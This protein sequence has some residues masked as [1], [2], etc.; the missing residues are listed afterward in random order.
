MPTRRGW[1]LLGA[2]VGLYAGARILGLVPLA[3]LAAQGGLLLAGAVTWTLTRRPQVRAGRE[4]SAC[5]QVGVE[6]RVGLDVTNTG[7]RRTPTLAVTDAFDGGRGTSRFLVAPLA[8]GGSSRA[9]YRIPTDRRG[10]YRLGPL[11]LAAGDPF[12]LARTRRRAAGITEVIVHPRVHDVIAPPERGGD[13]LDY[14]ARS[15]RG[16]PEPG[17]EFHTLRDYEHGDDLRRVHWR[18]T[19]RRGSLMIRQEEAR[20]RAPVV[21][22]L[23]VRSGGHDRAS[24]ETAVEAAASIIAALIRDER[25][26]TLFTT[27]GERVG[28]PGRRHLASV[29]DAL[30]VIE[31]GGPDRMTALLG[32][33]RAAALVA[34]MGRMR[35]GDAA[36]LTLLVRG[37][38]LLALVATRDAA[39]ALPGRRGTSMVVSVGHD[40]PFDRAWNECILRWEHGTARRR[41]ASLSQ[42]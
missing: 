11:H 18:S 28:S 1:S 10:L 33:R 36:A 15:V 41:P 20:R 22:L 42:R 31:P 32:G 13:D 8:P 21:V 14:D 3:L 2:I 30:A 16:R 19:A 39:E 24:F 26:V 27:T 4:V 6:G 17:G 12:G 7:R 37:S 40:A 9:A 38:G 35:D 23:D 5:L 29:L 34:I 25:P